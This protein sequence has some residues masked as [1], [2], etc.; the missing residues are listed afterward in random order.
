MT[1]EV[2]KD[3]LKSQNASCQK[4]AFSNLSQTYRRKDDETAEASECTPSQVNWR[5]HQR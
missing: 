5:G 1:S 4:C 2:P 3:L